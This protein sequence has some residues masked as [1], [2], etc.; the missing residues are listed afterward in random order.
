MIFF[1][2][3]YIENPKGYAGGFRQPSYDF[4]ILSNIENPTGYAGGYHQPSYD[5]FVLS[6][7]EPPA[8]LVGAYRWPSYDKCF[9][10]L[11]QLCFLLWSIIF[12][13]IAYTI[14]HLFFRIKW[15]REAWQGAKWW[16]KIWQRQ[17]SPGFRQ[18][19]DQLNHPNLPDEDNPLSKSSSPS[20][21]TEKLPC[22]CSNTPCYSVFADANLLVKKK[23]RSATRIH[24][25][26]CHQI[27]RYFFQ[28]LHGIGKSVCYLSCNKYMNWP[29]S[30]VFIGL[31]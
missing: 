8:R 5:F 27:C 10:F 20:S 26:H 13:D 16:R 7:I 1:I 6:N 24:Y 22:N 14:L 17:S 11:S 25:Y 29:S 12:Q 2:L 18:Q 15:W 30:L 31:F 4:F 21:G 23:E 28:Y 19:A 3:S 9:F